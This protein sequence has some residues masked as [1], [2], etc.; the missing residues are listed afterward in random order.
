[1]DGTNPFALAR[2]QASG[3]PVILD[4]FGSVQ[5]SFSGQSDISVCGRKRV[6]EHQVKRKPNTCHG[7]LD[8]AS[9]ASVAN[10]EWDIFSPSFPSSFRVHDVSQSCLVEV[11]EHT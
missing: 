10:C 8:W 5:L 3:S 4:T 7:S 6:A 2:D 9:T 11:S 1:M